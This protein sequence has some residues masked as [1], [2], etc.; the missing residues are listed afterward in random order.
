MPGIPTIYE[1]DGRG[2]IRRSLTQA[3]GLPNADPPAEPTAAEPTAEWVLRLTSGNCRL[4]F[5]DDDRDGEPI[6]HYQPVSTRRLLAPGTGMEA[7]AA[8]TRPSI[9]R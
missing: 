7:L 4:T 8:P 1:P 9:E 5:V 2:P 6:V 3:Y